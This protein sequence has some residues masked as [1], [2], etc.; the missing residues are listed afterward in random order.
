MRQ[1]AARDAG[2]VFLPE[3]VLSSR[4]L[5][6]WILA[7]PDGGPAAPDRDRLVGV[8]AD[9][10]G[11]DDMF[12]SV[13]RRLP[14]DVDLPYWVLDPAV[15]PGDHITVHEPSGMS[16]PEVRARLST[17]ADRP[18]D[19]TKPLWSV[20]VILDVQGVPGRSGLSTIVAVSFHHVAFDAIGWERRMHTLL[21]D[22]PV[23]HPGPLAIGPLD[24]PWAFTVA[25]GVLRAP[26]A[27]CR[28]L[29]LAVGALR[30]GRRR[31]R[32]AASARVVYDRRR[33][34]AT[35]FNTGVT[36]SRH[37]DFLDLALSAVEG[38]AAL[39]PGATTNDALLSIVGRAL[40]IHLDTIG[41]APVGSLVCLVPKTTRARRTDDDPSA[42]AN[43]F[44]PLAVDLHT[45][46]GDVR[47]RL[48]AIAESSRAEKLRA[49][50]VQNSRFWQ[51]VAT[52]PAHLM[53]LSGWVARHRAIRPGPAV[54]V[55]TVLSTVV[56]ATPVATV[57]SIPVV[58]GFGFSPLGGETTL[59][60]LA[61][62]GLG[63]VRLVATA[64]DSVLPDLSAYMRAMQ[65]SVD[66][67]MAAVRSA[68]L[69]SGGRVE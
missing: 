32:Q 4:V 45:D 35:R 67:H 44:V 38:V 62:I 57:A 54:A 27:W 25:R 20:D 26:I 49:E 31:S 60:H 33:A 66:E 42:P 17:V 24:G 10:L 6:C 48:A 52:A 46:I 37:T 39:V 9:R 65:E 64:D 15:D 19:M 30:E 12:R 8:L 13:L 22:V 21:A 41:E 3:T 29:P 50:A 55:N 11:V 56:N 58:S 1:V 18:F 5:S 36:G 53:R 23:R 69:V 61:V 34:P 51:A 59:A 7:T 14:A 68:P 40:L 63:R 28:F 16:W 43:Q 2:Y 47:D